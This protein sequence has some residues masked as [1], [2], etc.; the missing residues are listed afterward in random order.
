MK[1][2]IE[3][4]YAKEIIDFKCPRY[5]DF[6]DIGLYMEQLIEI[7][8]Q[9]LAIFASHPNEKLITSTMVNNYVKQKIIVPPKNKKYSRHQLIYLF[10]VGILKQVL[11]ISDIAELIKWELEMYPIDVAYNFFC[12]EFEKGL[13]AAFVTRDFSEPSSASKDTD[14]SELFR[15]QLLAVSNKIYV[16]KYMQYRRE[17]LNE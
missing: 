8:N 7:L 10:V 1:S 13:N 4:K 9:N 16:T 6:P 12:V 14:I 17:N 15:S 3:S 2:F 11:S 5:E